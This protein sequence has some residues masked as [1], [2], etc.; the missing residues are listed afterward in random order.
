[1]DA[2]LPVDEISLE[3]I[4]IFLEKPGVS[5]VQDPVGL[6][7]NLVELSLGV[8]EELHHESWKTKKLQGL[9]IQ[10]IAKGF[11][12]HWCVLPYVML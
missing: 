12:A 1:M 7:E 11:I 5:L 2:D 9:I 8:T 4:E 6:S 3:L 10:I